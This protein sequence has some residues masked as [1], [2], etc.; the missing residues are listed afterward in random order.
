MIRINLIPYRTARSQRRIIQH[1]SVFFAVVI[2]AFLLTLGTHTFVSLQLADLKE[3]TMSLQKQNRDL[4][5]KIG[6]I[7]NLDHLRA[8]VERKLKIVDRLQEGRFFSLNTLHEIAAV[9]PGNVWLNQINE[10]GG[11]VML[12][13]LAESNKAVAVF[14]R[15]LD[16]SPMFSNVRLDVIR[17]VIVNSLPLRQFSLKLI[18]EETSGSTTPAHKATS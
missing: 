11:S 8:N 1:L 17:R 2:F 10:G 7:E 5:Q 12:T 6:K 18:R 15:K 16:Q 13:G 3:G 9:I 4:K 14:M